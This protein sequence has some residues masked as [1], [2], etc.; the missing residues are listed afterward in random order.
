MVRLL[1]VGIYSLCTV[2]FCLFGAHR[3]W[4]LWM[5]FKYRNHPDEKHDSLANDHASHG[6]NLPIDS[7]LPL[8]PQS[9]PI[10]TIQ[11]PIYNEKFVVPRLVD[12]VC[13]IEYPRDRLEI[14]VLDDSTDETAGMVDRLVQAKQ[15]E[16]LDIKAIRRP[17][18]DN[19]KAG[20]LRYGL[21]QSRGELLLIF[22]ADFIPPSNLLTKA[23]PYFQ[24]PNVGLVQ[25]P[26][27]HINR[28]YSLLTYAQALLLDGHF[29]IEHLARSRSGRFFNFNGTAGIWRKH[30]IIDAGGWQ[31]DTLTEDMDLSYRA[32]LKGWKFLFVPDV[33]VPAELPV[34][35]NA[36]KS[37]QYRW[38]KGGI[39]TAMKLLPRLLRSPVPFKVKLEAIFHLTG[40][41]TYLLIPCLIL[42]FPVLITCISCIPLPMYYVA[43]GAAF[44]SII[45]FYITA[46][47]EHL[48][49]HFWRSLLLI[50][51]LMAVSIG[52]CINNS[53]AVLGA[54]LARKSEFV[55]TPKYDVRKRKDSWKRRK[56]YRM[57]IN[58]YFLIELFFLF[59]TLWLAAI[60]WMYS[61]YHLIPFMVIFTFGFLYFTVLTLRQLY[62]K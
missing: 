56:L 41:L 32:Q 11:L 26:W 21:E 28:D 54:L 42:V 2:V 20:A 3:L 10:V 37:Q 7:Y 34:E 6:T 62:I 47:A 16:G 53:R 36:F 55:R 59:Y 18:R 13:A 60:G 25:F 49:T 9:L 58:A 45:T 61:A 29:N 57:R 1:M 31:G 17:H 5:Y 15:A 24:D 30:C 51:V 19:F 23:V 40:N 35:L 14:Q 8:A 43:F 22:D 52:L 38:A 33:R 12:A 27:G 39:Q 50:P 48:R 4:M 46:Q 44:L